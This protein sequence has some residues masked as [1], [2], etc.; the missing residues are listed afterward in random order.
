MPCRDNFAAAH[1][2]PSGAEVEYMVG[3]LDERPRLMA[4]ITITLCYC[5]LLEP[6]WWEALAT[7]CGH[8]R[9]QPVVAR[10]E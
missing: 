10:R 7:A 8:P 9:M 4:S 1:A 2:P 6:S 3:G 5:P